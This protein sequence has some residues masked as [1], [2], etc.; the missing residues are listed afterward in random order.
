MLQPSGVDHPQ[1]N[2]AAAAHVCRDTMVSH[3][4]A[5]VEEKSDATEASMPSD[6]SITKEKCPDLPGILNY[7]R[8]PGGEPMPDE[9]WQKLK[10]RVVTGPD[11]PRLKEFVHGVGNIIIFCVAY[12]VHV[13]DFNT[14][15][16]YDVDILYV[17]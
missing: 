13:V 10:E 16:M 9:L 12:R 3:A 5:D 6:A 4:V 17:M 11:D 14:H 8:N 15:S 1:E 2:Y 7:M